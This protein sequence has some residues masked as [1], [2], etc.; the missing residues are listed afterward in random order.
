MKSFLF[1]CYSKM[2]ESQ[3][4]PTHTCEL[5]EYNRKTKTKTAVWSPLRLVGVNWAVF[6]VGEI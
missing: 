1:P 5:K 3:F 4:S 2:A 6:W